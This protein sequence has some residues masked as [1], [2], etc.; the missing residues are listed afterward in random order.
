MFAEGLNLSSS[1][2][3]C[4]LCAAL[5]CEP[6]M[7]S[8]KPQHCLTTERGHKE[9]SSSRVTD[10]DGAAAHDFQSLKCEKQNACTEKIIYVS[11]RWVN[12]GLRL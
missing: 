7:E 8:L 9:P 3:I 1:A 2:A 11:E 4:F 6:L 12:L 10:G 5:L